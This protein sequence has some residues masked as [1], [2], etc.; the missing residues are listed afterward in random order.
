MRVI[1]HLASI[2]VFLMICVTK[3]KETE[4][5][6]KMQGAKR[7][8]LGPSG[9]GGGGGG[10]S[11]NTAPPAS[12][13]QCAVCMCEHLFSLPAPPFLPWIIVIVIVV[14]SLLSCLSLSHPSIT[15]LLRTHAQALSSPRVHAPLA[16]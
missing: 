11:A 2:S 15:P 8:K 9:G 12:S 14:V 10:G 4:L 5:V 13:R 7:R 1:C 6:A 3:K 16:G